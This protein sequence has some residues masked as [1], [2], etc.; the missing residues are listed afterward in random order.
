MTDKREREQTPEEAEAA[1]ARVEAAK[2]RA[3]RAEAR[4]ARLEREQ[5][6]TDDAILR[7]EKLRRITERAAA[8]QRVYVVQPG[9]SLSKIAKEVYGDASRW[10]EIAE[11]NKDEVPDPNLIHPGQELIIP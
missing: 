9:D 8:Q 2:K 7:K 1:A 4:A 11:A 6:D 3:D 10:P 5:R